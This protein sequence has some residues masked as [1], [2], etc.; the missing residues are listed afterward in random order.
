MYL[1][2]VV[3]KSASIKGGFPKNCGGIDKI[4]QLLLNSWQKILTKCALI[5]IV[6]DSP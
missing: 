6:V 5:E 1:Y 2:R 4:R 3:E